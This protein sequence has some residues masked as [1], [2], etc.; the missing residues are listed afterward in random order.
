M[1]PHTAAVPMHSAHVDGTGV[2]ITVL[3]SRP[4]THHN[5]G[6]QLESCAGVRWPTHGSPQ[7]AI[8]A[9]SLQY[10]SP[11]TR[12]SRRRPDSDMCKHHKV[13][14]EVAHLSCAPMTERRHNVTWAHPHRLP[15][16]CARHNISSKACC[17]SFAVSA[18]MP[19]MVRLQSRACHRG[20]CEWTHGCT[21]E[22]W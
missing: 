22:G 13:N 17:H 6:W 15:T 14:E 10:S 19:Q 18:C 4:S 21:T 11:C 12:T 9:V 20:L 3:T 2:R 1:L 5:E 16:A 7:R 8:D